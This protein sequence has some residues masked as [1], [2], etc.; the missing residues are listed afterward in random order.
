LQRQKQ[1]NIKIIS[2]TIVQD[3]QFALF[4]S[5]VNLSLTLQPVA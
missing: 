1:M 3:E 2:R 5:Y 4:A